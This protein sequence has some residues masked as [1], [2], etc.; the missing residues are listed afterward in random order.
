MRLRIF[1]VLLGALVVALT[2]TFPLW[3]PLLSQQ[4]SDAAAEIIPGLPPNLQEQFV[5]FTP[6]QQQAYL[7]VAAE[8]PSLAVAM[9]RAA[10]SPPIPAPD[11]MRIVPSMNG[12]V[13]IGGGEFE[14]IDAVRWGSGE[15]TVYEQ[16]DGSKVVRFEGFSVSNGPNLRVVLSLSPAP[17]TPE[18]MRLN[19]REIEI[20]QLVG[21]T[22]SQNY[23][24]AAE[25][26]IR[27]Y[28]S[29]VIYSASLDLIYSYAPLALT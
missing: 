1:I 15:A 14:R 4:G 18:E 6:E 2:F 26:N 13:D 8:D 16:A 17:L 11:E 7:T 29:I 22:G 25:I 10:L 27:E 24:V 28:R 9:I 23:A 21:T 12:P 20:G 3:Q 19:A 5:T